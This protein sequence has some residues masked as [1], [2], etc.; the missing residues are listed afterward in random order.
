[1]I[2]GDSPGCREPRWEVKSA[3]LAWDVPGSKDHAVLFPL[4]QTEA[5]LQIQM[6]DANPVIGDCHS[7]LS[8][9]NGWQFR[10]GIKMSPATCQ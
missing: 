5:A 7:G 10:H 4:Q 3:E 8:L 1:M 6:D 2:G 9:E